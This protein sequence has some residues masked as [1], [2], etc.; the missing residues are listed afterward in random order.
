MPFLGALAPE[1]GAAVVG[2][3]AQLVGGL[4]GSRA[5]GKATDANLQATR[6]ALAYQKERD[7]REE[8]MARRQWEAYQVGR[9]YL[10]Q[11]YGIPVEL[12]TS[13]GAAPTPRGTGNVEAVM[14]TSATPSG[15]PP[16]MGKWNDWRSYGLR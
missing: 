13:G 2:G 3:G 12:P 4:I 15:T 9:N 16:A 7:A 1:V 8:E 6:E 10:L 11:R 14:R 5:Q